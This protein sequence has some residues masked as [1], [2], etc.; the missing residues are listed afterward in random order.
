MSFNRWMYVEGNPVNYTDPSGHLACK[1]VIPSARPLFE[2]LRLCNPNETPSEN[3]NT[4]GRAQQFEDWL[5]DKCGIGYTPF[6]IVCV[7]TIVND[8]TDIECGDKA[9][10]FIPSVPFQWPVPSQTCQQL[11]ASHVLAIMQ[12]AALDLQLDAL[13]DRLRDTHRDPAK[14]KEIMEQ[15]KKK[16][17]D[18]D[19]IV[20]IL[21][22]LK[23][24]AMAKGC[25][26]AED[27]PDPQ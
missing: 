17:A 5:Y 25:P 13:Y 18:R 21:R 27:W 20:I 15:I 11:E 16:Q 12:L 6:G 14:I 9:P 19:K 4:I 1:D 23:K 2:A 22:I 26:T 3:P 8:A 10:A 7:P 24:D